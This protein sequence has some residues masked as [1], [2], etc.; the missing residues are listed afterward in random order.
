MNYELLRIGEQNIF[1]IYYIYHTHAVTVYTYSLTIRHHQQNQL[2]G[3]K[4]Q[5]EF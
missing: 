1:Y 3:G 4:T 5:G 2:S